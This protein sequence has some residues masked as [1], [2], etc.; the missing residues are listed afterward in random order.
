M[1][2]SDN[3]SVGPCI[4]AINTWYGR[5]DIPIGKVED[6]RL[7]YPVYKGGEEVPSA[8]T[9]AVAK[10]FPHKLARSSEA[11][12]AVELYRKILSAQP[13]RSVVVISV[14][15]L[16]NLKNLLNSG[17]DE[18]SALKGE[19]LVRAKVTQLVCMGGKF[20]D[21]QF[22]GGGGEYN[23][24][25]DTE[26]SIRA[27]HDWPTPVVFSGWEIGNA[28]KVGSKLAAREELNPVRTAYG[29][30]NNLQDREAWDLTAVLFAV[31]GAGELW[32]LSEPG[33]C[34]MHAGI[35][36]GYNEWIADGKHQHR[37]LIQ[38]SAPEK[39]AEVLNE[40]LTAPPQNHAAQVRG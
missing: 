33:F 34:L 21:G 12:R 37:Y 31:R 23:V 3:E 28:I 2:S 29:F 24:A 20:P 30:F 8:Y 22:P 40:L 14:G 1:I 39:V 25:W 17:P 18:I 13:D 9:H 11:P 7:A 38:K 27:I 5:P 32:S 26:A 16:T 36:H 4:E 19:E 15:F 6:L 35:P 10:A